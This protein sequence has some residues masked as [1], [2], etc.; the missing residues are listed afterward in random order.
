[1]NFSEW[2]NQIENFST[3]AERLYGDIEDGDPETIMR[4][5]RAAYEVGFENGFSQILD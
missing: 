3:R 5:I 2:L 4:W 1:M